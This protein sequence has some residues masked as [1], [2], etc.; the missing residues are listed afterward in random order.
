MVVT[1]L[2]KTCEGCPAQWEGRLVGGRMLYIRYRWG[3][4]SVRI[5]KGITNDVDEAV[6]GI[7]MFGKNVGGGLDGTMEFE[8]LEFHTQGIINFNMVRETKCNL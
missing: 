4:L 8:M 3:Y 1:E 2:K 7:E 5:S 6:R